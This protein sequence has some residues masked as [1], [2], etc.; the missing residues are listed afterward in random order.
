MYLSYT[1]LEAEDR[2]SKN[3]PTQTKWIKVE[4]TVKSVQ[5]LE[6]KLLRN[7]RRKEKRG[8]FKHQKRLKNHLVV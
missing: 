7:Q 6:K 4:F 5:M 2:H 1:G 3:Y 8:D